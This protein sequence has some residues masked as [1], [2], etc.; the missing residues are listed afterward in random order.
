M[1]ILAVSLPLHMDKYL[2]LVFRRWRF[3]CLY[4]E[5][6]KDGDPVAGE[7]LTVTDRFF[8]GCFEPGRYILRYMKSSDSQLPVKSGSRIRSL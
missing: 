3:V 1:L 4:A 2:H 8:Y 5:L 7:W 6:S